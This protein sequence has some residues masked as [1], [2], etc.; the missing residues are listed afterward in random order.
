MGKKKSRAKYVS[1][2]ERHAIAPENRVKR[3]PIKN[4]LD[5]QEAFSKGK[6]VYFTIPN[7]NPNETNKRFIRVEGKLLYGDFRK[8]NERFIIR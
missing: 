3:D 5:K 2:G 1:K 6:K 7:P 8:F 4:I